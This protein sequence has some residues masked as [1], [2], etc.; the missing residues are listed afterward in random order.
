[1]RTYRELG[2]EDEPGA[3]RLQVR[4]LSLL[5][6]GQRLIAGTSNGGIY[7]LSPTASHWERLFKFY[8][9]PVHA[10]KVHRQELFIATNQ[11]KRRKLPVSG[12]N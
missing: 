7:E 12:L 2:M 11:I 10:M 1:M 4:V 5:W 8:S 6:L 9:L 3:G